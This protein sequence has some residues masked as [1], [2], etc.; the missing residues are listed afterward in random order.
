MQNNNLNVKRNELK[1]YINN[2]EYTALYKRLQHALKPDKYSTPGKGYF[3][4]SLY[5]DSYNDTCLY[6]KQSGVQY[7][8][9]YRLRIYDLNASTVK[10][11][12]KNKANNQVHKESATISRD[13]ADKIIA[14]EYDELLKY[15]NP[16]LNRAFITFSTQL[17]RPKVIIDYDRDAFMYDH[18]NLR[19]TIDK[20][21][22]ANNTN[23]DLFSKD[24]HC[25]PA[26][27][28]QKQIL[29]VKYTDMMPDYIKNLLQLDSQERQ[30]ISKYTLGRRFLKTRNWEDN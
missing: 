19:I 3:I 8:Q 25:I 23:F 9:K 12:I 16:L 1:Y 21:L 27:L 11:E 22:R 20:H 10:F 30:A 13:S 5:F 7:R 2:I 28:E 15:N 6:Q 26:I 29:E 24:T 14:G 4:R 17:Y 18:F